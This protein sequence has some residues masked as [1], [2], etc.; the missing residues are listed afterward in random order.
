MC[1]R[2]VDRRALHVGRHASDADA[3][4]DRAA[5]GGFQRAVADISYSALPGGS[6][7]TRAHAR[8]A[9]LQIFR[10]A[11][12]RAA[13]ATGGHEGIDAPAGLLPDLRARGSHVRLAIGG[14]V[15]LVGP[16]R[17]RQLRGQPSSHFLVVVGVGCRARP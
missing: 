13:G 6:A 5:A 16:D 15:E 7:S 11:R 9:R 3:L 10:D 8:G 1:T 17:V 14:I 2:V 4:G 12:Q